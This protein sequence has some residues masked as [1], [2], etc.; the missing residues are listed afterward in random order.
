MQIPGIP[1]VSDIIYDAVAVVHGMTHG[2]VLRKSGDV[3][4]WRHTDFPAP[5]EDPPSGVLFQ[6]I[7]AGD[8]ISI[9]L[10]TTGRV[11][12]WGKEGWAGAEPLEA[13]VDGAVARV[14]VSTVTVTGC[15]LWKDSGSVLCFGEW[16]FWDESAE[17]NDLWCGGDQVVMRR[18]RDGAF[19]YSGFGDAAPP[20]PTTLLDN[21]PVVDFTFG[22]Q[23]SMALLANGSLI[24]YNNLQY[25]E[26]SWMDTLGT[27][28]SDVSLS[29]GLTYFYIRPSD[30][31][32]LYHILAADM[33]TYF[34]AMSVPTSLLTNGIEISVYLPNV[35]ALRQVGCNVIRPSATDLSLTPPPTI[36]NITLVNDAL[37][38][39]L[40]SGFF[41]TQ[42]PSEEFRVFSFSV[43]GLGNLQFQKTRDVWL[44]AGAAND[45]A[46]IERHVYSFTELSAQLGPG[47][48]IDNGSALVYDLNVEVTWTDALDSGQSRVSS[49]MFPTRI[50]YPYAVSVTSQAVPADSNNNTDSLLLSSYRM[51]TPTSLTGPNVLD[52]TL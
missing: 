8:G 39:L 38:V 50:A 41:G 34:D 2:L 7:A 28:A 49:L 32:V 20:N 35:I 30:G 51:T 1:G 15:I 31:R 22:T 12:T 52:V 11:Y 40:Y 9:G 45:C 14:C 43:N 42:N 37:T 33:Q 27:L 29:T 19:V 18:A 25:Y 6:Q 48:R 4:Q 10:S 26:G 13:R 5:G 3:I 46:F 16:N 36:Y 47:A 21:L 23:S 17:Y 44:S 24:F